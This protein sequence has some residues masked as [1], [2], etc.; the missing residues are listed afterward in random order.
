MDKIL[1]LGNAGV[2][3]TIGVHLSGAENAQLR[4]SF[5]LGISAGF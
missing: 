4:G 1:A 5:A 2:S 3:V